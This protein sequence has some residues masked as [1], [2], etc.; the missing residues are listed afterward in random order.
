MTKVRPSAGCGYCVVRGCLEAYCWI[1]GVMTGLRWRETWRDVVFGRLIG[2]RLIG[3]LLSLIRG[4]FGLLWRTL[5]GSVRL[6]LR[7]RVNTRLCVL[8]WGLFRI[9][10]GVRRVSGLLGWWI[11][12]LG[13]YIR[14]GLLLGSLIWWLL[15]RGR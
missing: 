14:L 3:L 7:W 15:G 10:T 1:W 12:G 6:V 9:V 5:V 8:M 13:W 2:Y 4:R 11:R